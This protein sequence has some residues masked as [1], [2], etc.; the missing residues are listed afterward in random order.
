MEP[1]LQHSRN[2]SPIIP[3]HLFLII[4]SHVKHNIHTSSAFSIIEV[5][6]GIFI[7]SL[8]LVS[9]YALLASSLRIS[10]YNNNAIIAS[11]LA[12]EQIELFRNIRDTNYKKLQVW[13]QTYPKSSNYSDVF[14]PDTYYTLENNT[15][16]PATGEIDVVALWSSVP[17]WETQLAA[18][19]A[20][21][22]LC[23]NSNNIYTYT[24]WADDRSIFH[25]YLYITE[26]SPGS[27]Q[28]N[29]K[30]IWYKRGYYEYEIQTIVTDWRRI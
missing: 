13:D 30:V 16:T 5:L 2:R 4:N 8:W 22:G 23:V 1:F 21:Y 12:R 24:C 29:S 27:Y 15:A 10:D 20:S 3:S 26:L 25:R 28:V 11:N 14:L 19:Q 6:I 18:M 17:E 7:F 9:I